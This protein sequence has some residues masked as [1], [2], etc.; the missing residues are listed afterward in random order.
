MENSDIGELRSKS[1]EADDKVMKFMSFC[2]VSLDAIEENSPSAVKNQL[3][4]K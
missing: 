2:N 3:F 1:S 4:I